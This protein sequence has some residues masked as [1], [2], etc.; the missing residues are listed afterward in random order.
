MLPEVT[1]Q[2]FLIKCT[3]FLLIL[4]KTIKFYGFE[5]ILSYK[6]P[7][8][9]NGRPKTKYTKSKRQQTNVTSENMKKHLKNFSEIG[10]VVYMI[11]SQTVRIQFV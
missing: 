4:L 3:I 5:V 1:V 7:Q 10:T 9:L 11:E 6:R 8:F 2:D